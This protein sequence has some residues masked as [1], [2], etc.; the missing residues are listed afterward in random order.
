MIGKNHQKKKK[1]V[2]DL[3][4][5]Y[6]E[7][8]SISG[9]TDNGIVTAK[10]RE[11][12]RALCKDEFTLA[13][14]GEAKAGKS[15]LINALLGEQVLPTDALQSSNTIIKIC[16]S[17]RYFVKVCYANG[18]EQCMPDDTST[19]DLD[20]VAKLLREVASVKDKYRSIPAALIDSYMV[21]RKVPLDEG[22]RIQDDIALPMDEWARDSGIRLNDE[23]KELVKSY[24]R[25]R[26]LD[27]IPVSIEIGRKLNY[28]FD[29]FRL[30]DSPGV[31]AVG[32]VQHA[33]FNYLWKANAFL[34]VHS[35]KSPVEMQ[36]LRKFITECATERHKD[37]LILVLTHR[38]SVG[39]TELNSKIDEARSQFSEWI[40][41]DR[42]VGVDSI[43]RL[44]GIDLLK[45]ETL[46]DLRSQYELQL[47]NYNDEIS[48]GAK[49]VRGSAVV[50]ENKL[51]HVKEI[52]YET[53]DDAGKEIARTKLDDKANF[54]TLE[55]SLN[56]LVE[57]SQD[58]LLWDIL[59]MIDHGYGEIA[60][61]LDNELCLLEEE[62]KSPQSIET[63]IW[64]M[65]RVLEQHQLAM[66]A[67]P[68]K[69]AGEYTG[70]NSRVA[71]K[72]ES[73]R[74][75]LESDLDTCKTVPE[76]R[77]TLGNYL[78]N[79]ND[80]IVC[81]QNEIRE[82]YQRKQNDL[83]VEVKS[84]ES[85]SV[86]EVDLIGL[87]KVAEEKAYEE[88]DVPREA[89]GF[90]E[91][92]LRVLSFWQW[93][94]TEKSRK[95]NEKTHLEK[96]QGEAIALARDSKWDG[97]GIISGILSNIA[98]AFRSELESEVKSHKAAL[99]DFSKRQA[100]NKDTIR[101]IR[102]AQ[103]RKEFVNDQRNRIQEFRENLR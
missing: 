102:T 92:V 69:L 56:E 89:K 24:V 83:H 77:I 45:H 14:V 74:N 90:S 73:I 103:G 42:I 63:E 41:V 34:F 49:E 64:N 96:A 72:F 25:E 15:T 82:A 76:V 101:D 2:R 53:R 9:S 87:M 100:E 21:A 81:F 60:K 84:T 75:A 91:S 62:R 48:S 12:V 88:K 70:R 98:K 95:L 4:D 59:S 8:K 86:P 39:E 65:K 85:I 37:A 71:K 33:T 54:G 13:V 36:S 50:V 55:E 27:Q 47:K 3:V 46:E 80:V 10:L 20:E 93:R 94:P 51:K 43:I 28:A 26:C 1:I 40:H 99:D 19:P 61:R 18:F 52:L 97:P 16:N 22:G 29:G 31:N 35:A 57:R 66:N 30:V 58:L 5:R 7:H 32:G 11:R 68:E 44:I 78:D 6:N 23:R 38:G 79:F 67:F 17:E